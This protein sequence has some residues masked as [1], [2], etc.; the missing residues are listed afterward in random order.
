[1]KKKVRD[2][3]ALGRARMYAKAYIG[4]CMRW[5]GEWS[6]CAYGWECAY[7]CVLGVVAYMGNK[8]EFQINQTKGR[9]EGLTRRRDSLK[10]RKRET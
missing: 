6:K 3:K 5:R 8:K 9:I 1:M 10:R 7:G 2:K 4:Y